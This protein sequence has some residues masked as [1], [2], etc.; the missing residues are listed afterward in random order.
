MISINTFV[1]GLLLGIIGVPICG[2]LVDMIAYVTEL[3]KAK[4]SV[5]IAECNQAVS[6]LETPQE[7]QTKTIGFSIPMPDEEEE[8]L[9]E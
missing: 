4:I 9:D 8:Y 2:Y 1:L 7:E 3:V 5:K 6:K